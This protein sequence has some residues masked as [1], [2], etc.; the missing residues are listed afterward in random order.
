MGP[1]GV[2]QKEK[3]AAGWRQTHD[4][5]IRR[6]VLNR[7]A[8]AIHNGNKYHVIQIRRFGATQFFKT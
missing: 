4:L 5:R 1:G 2:E 6:T 8:T 3:V 7:C